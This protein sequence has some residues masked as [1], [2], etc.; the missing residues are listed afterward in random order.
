MADLILD[1]DYQIL[2]EN[3]EVLIVSVLSNRANKFFGS[4]TPW[5]EGD[6]WYEL[7]QFQKRTSAGRKIIYIIDK[8]TNEKYGFLDY[9]DGVI[10]QTNTSYI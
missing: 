5:Y 2:F 8:K 1:E 6:N 3:D 10:Y 9:K 4:G 7:S